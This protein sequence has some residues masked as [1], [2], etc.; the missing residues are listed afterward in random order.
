MGLIGAHVSASGGVATAFPRASAIGCDALQLFVKNASTW[1]G[2]ALTDAQVAAF[3][4]ARRATPG[5]GVPAPMPTIAHASYLV[6]LASP[7]DTLRERSIAALADEL[8]RC[9]RLGVDALVVHPGA[10]TGSGVGA[11]IEAVA[12]SVDAVLSRTDGAATLLLLENTAGQ[13]T[14]LGSTPTE[15]GSM[16]AAVGDRARVGVCLDTCHAFAAG[17]DLREED[18]YESFL[19]AVDA[20]VG[21]DRVHAWHLNDSKGDLGSNKDRHENIGDG[22]IGTGAFAR[23]IGDDRFASLPMILETPLGDDELGHERDLVTLRA[24]LG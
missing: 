4:E 19:A 15:L 3:H 14:V 5:Q 23:L 7:D 11:G 21:L 24:L 1:R 18:G 20:A 10:H 12:R 13:G 8:Q 6:N 9:A 22:A 17:A 16:L 2:A